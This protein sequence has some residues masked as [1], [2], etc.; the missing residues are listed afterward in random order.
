MRERE[1]ERERDRQKESLFRMY[2]LSENNYPSLERVNEASRM[3]KNK[4]TSFLESSTVMSKEK[5]LFR[6]STLLNI[7]LGLS[8][9]TSKRA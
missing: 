6:F 1:R 2:E 3:S 5:F 9:R 7:Q 8:M 4:E